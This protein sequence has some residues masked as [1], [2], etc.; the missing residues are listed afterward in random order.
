MTEEELVE[1]IARAICLRRGYDPEHL[2]P[3]NAIQ[4]W[5]DEESSREAKYDHM[6]DSGD[7][8]PDGHNGKEQVSFMWRWFIFDARAAL[9]AI[10]E[11][12]EMVPRSGEF[13]CGLCGVRRGGEHQDGEPAF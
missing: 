13:I 7:V 12:H 11:T 8:Q 2:E 9:A 6:F 5:M 10:R 1:R 4:T 3:G